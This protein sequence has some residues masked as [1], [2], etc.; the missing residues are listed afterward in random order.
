MKSIVS[1][2]SA[3]LTV[4]TENGQV[5]L[6]REALTT[7]ASEAK[8]ATI[9]LEVVTVSK[10][11]EA[12]QKAAGTNGYII[13]LVIKSGDKIIS[14]FNK[15]KATVTVEIPAKL[16]DKKVAAIYITEDGKI[17]QLEGKTVKIDGKKY[18]T[19][20]TPHFSAFALVDAEE[21]GLEVNDEEQAK[22][23]KLIAGVENTTLKASSKKAAS[24][25]KITW[26][27]S[28]GYRM[29]YYEVFRS[30]KRYSGFGKVAFYTTKK[31]KNPLK[32]YYVN[33]GK[34]KEGTRYYYKVRGVRI[35]D[36]KKYYTQWS[37]KVWRVA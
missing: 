36:G 28:K 21:L 11:T 7:V 33:T 2:T 18:Y 8:G 15:G 25:I 27:K 35:L 32:T 9:T 4:K 22:M 19:F 37:T 30:T 16:Q 20:E 34:L 5:S 24:G 14:D 3:S 29:D 12:Q 31:A 17:E 10:P 26:T 13:R 6:D 1:D 23:E